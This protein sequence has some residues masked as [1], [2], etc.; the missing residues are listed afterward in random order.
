MKYKYFMI[1]IFLYLLVFNNNKLFSEGIYDNNIKT[2]MESKNQTYPIHIDTS[3]RNSFYRDWTLKNA[4]HDVDDWDLI[5]SEPLNDYDL[6]LTIEQKNRLERFINKFM[7]NNEYIHE[8][9]KISKTNTFSID[10]IIIEHH[11]WKNNEDD[12]ITLL[13]VFYS[14]HQINEAW[15]YDE[16]NKIWMAYNMAHYSFIND[17]IELLGWA[18]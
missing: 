4:R 7:I 14:D 16:K 10:N 6:V 3:L 15:F 13:I 8:L 17:I 12:N 9:K 1:V 18:I 5:I 2:Y 11:G